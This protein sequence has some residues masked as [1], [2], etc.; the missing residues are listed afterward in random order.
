MPAPVDAAANHPFAFV[1]MAVLAL[2]LGCARVA[3]ETK[4]SI[5]NPKSFVHM[6]TF[7]YLALLVVLMSITT[8]MA[9]VLLVAPDGK[10]A[11][12]IVHPSLVSM[13]AAVFGVF[14]FEILI[15]KF[16]I[17]F[18]ENKFDVSTTLQYV[19]DQAAAAT[20]KKEVG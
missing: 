13:A 7:A 2:I 16:V 12:A 17:G 9:L 20:F 10:P 15:S 19:V 3:H 14:G 6:W 11:L 5:K 18:G 4:V 8:D 1:I